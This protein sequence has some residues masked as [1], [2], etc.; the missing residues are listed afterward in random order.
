MLATDGDLDAG[1]AVRAY[2]FCAAKGQQPE[3]GGAVTVVYLNTQNHTAATL[4]FAERVAPDSSIGGLARSERHVYALTSYPHLLT[5]RA[6]YL[7]ARTLLD[8]D[9]QTAEPVRM[10]PAVVEAGG[11]AVI[12]PA[13]Y[14]FVVFP[15]AGAPACK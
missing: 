7:N 1:R 8:V 12:A 9:R 15:M 11:D 6:V 4:R 10:D 2:S 14:G 13:S 3:G 5:S